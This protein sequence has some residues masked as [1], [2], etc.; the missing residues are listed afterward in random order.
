MTSL[1]QEIEIC[2]ISLFMALI[3]ELCVVP[4]RKTGCKFAIVK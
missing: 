3:T 1:T 4:P 2:R